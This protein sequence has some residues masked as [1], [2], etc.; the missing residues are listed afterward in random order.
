MYRIF[1]RCFI[2]KYFNFYSSKYSCNIFYKLI[3][4]Y[5]D[6]SFSPFFHVNF[7]NSI[8]FCIV[9]SV[10]SYVLSRFGFYTIF[11]FSIGK[12]HRSLLLTYIFLSIKRDMRKIFRVILIRK[13]LNRVTITVYVA[14]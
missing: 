5:Y 1:G 7:C 10:F 13:Q 3:R 14:S 12:L 9:Y 2:F 11:S 6:Y 8:L 4:C